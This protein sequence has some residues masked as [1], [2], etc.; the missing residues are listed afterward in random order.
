MVRPLLNRVLLRYELLGL[1]RDTR[2]LVLSVLLPIVL[3]PILLFTL[4]RLGQ[5]R[6]GDSSDGFRYSRTVSSPGLEGLTR[7]VFAQ[8]SFREMGVGDDQKMLADG[9]LDLVLRVTPPEQVDPQLGQ[10]IVQAFPTLRD[11]ISSQQPGRPVVEILYRGDR[12]RSVRAYLQ[13]QDR[14]LDF[15]DKLLDGYL[16]QE[17]AEVGVQ[18]RLQDI[19]S[20]QERQARRYGPALSAFMLLILLG[21]GSVAALDSLAGERE[22]GTLST[23]FL[24]SLPRSEILWTKFTAVAIISLVVAVIQMINLAL[25]PLLGW[26]ELPV[27]L[28]W[29]Q[30]GAMLG[31]LSLL[32]L[33]ESL[34][35]ASLLLYISARSSSFKEAQLFFFPA[36]LVAFALSLSGLM[37]G[38]PSRSVIS[39]IPVA[40][41]GVL[42]PEVLASRID[43]PM[44]L[45]QVVVHVLAARWLLASIMA[46]MNREEFLGGQ[47]PAVGP[48]RLFEQ[49]SLRSLPFYALLWAALMVVPANFGF[50]STLQGQGLFNQLLLFV[51]GP[52]LLLRFYGQELRQAVPWRPVSWR[53]L[54]ASLA[55]IP[56]GQLAA[57]GL[58]HLLGPLL[59][60][61][62]KALEEMVAF[63][64][65]GNTPAWQIYLLIGILPGICEEIAFRGVLLYALHRRFGPWAL[66]AV[67]AAVF[68]LFHLTFY[69]VAPTAYLGFFLGLVTLATGS[70]WPAV[71]IHIGNNSLAVYALL[72][73]WQ[74]D[75]LGLFTYLTSFVGQ[76]AATALILRWGA[77]YPGTRWDK[78]RR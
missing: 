78:G 9:A 53:I 49:F 62:V 72:Y 70:L 40:G 50:L 38:L 56:L 15:R 31:C 35:T 7:S 11:L 22:R 75:D 58:S 26:M 10:D 67:V 45:L 48:A 2:T 30:G 6:Q 3:L 27:S 74:L 64:D 76:L 32:F 23:L 60:P 42:I 19:S 28:G 36:F 39:L 73:D 66:A 41:P 44:L 16:Q 51:L 34:F 20:V 18:A 1:A 52:L 5:Q 47:P 68:G 33:A 59:P 55:L 61:P 4:Q 29:Q 14:L 8:S 63:L 37:P 46:T 77:G 54:L 12:E 71:L 57:T 69:R 43:L 65:L 24:S 21:G 17:R 13:A 25:Y